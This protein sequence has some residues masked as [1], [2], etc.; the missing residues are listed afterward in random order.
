M[1]EVLVA[2]D[3]ADERTLNGFPVFA[4]SFAEVN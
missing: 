3:T 2:H 1:T 4:I